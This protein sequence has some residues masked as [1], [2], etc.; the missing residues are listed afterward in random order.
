VVRVAGDT[1][2]MAPPF[3]TEKSDLDEIFAIIRRVLATV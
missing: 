1:I 2:I 3:I